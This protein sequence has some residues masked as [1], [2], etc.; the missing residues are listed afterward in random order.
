VD[1]GD[2]RPEAGARKERYWFLAAIGPLSGK[3]GVV[4]GFYSDGTEVEE[5]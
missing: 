4:V 2:F 1:F 3:T 5:E